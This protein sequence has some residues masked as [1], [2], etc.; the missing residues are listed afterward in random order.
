MSQIKKRLLDIKKQSTLK[1]SV[2]GT[3]FVA[4]KQG[5]DALRCLRYNLRIM[6]IPMSSPSYI[7][8]DNM[9]ALD[10]TSRLE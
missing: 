8:G 6:G 5:I 1:S 7:Y 10:N 4:T 3:E 2:F 9:S